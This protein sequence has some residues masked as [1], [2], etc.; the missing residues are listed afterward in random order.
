MSLKELQKALDKFPE[1]DVSL[2][3]ISCQMNC[4]ECDKWKKD[5]ARKFAAYRAELEKKERSLRKLLKQL[6]KNENQYITARDHESTDSYTKQYLD[7]RR[8]ES[9]IIRIELEKLLEAQK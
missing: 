7:G 9:E 3:S 4:V 2:E 6:E 8:R 1:H 5:F